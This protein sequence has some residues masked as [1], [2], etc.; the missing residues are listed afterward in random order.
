MVLD[1]VWL[2]CKMGLVEFFLIITMASVIMCTWMAVSSTTNSLHQSGSG[3][4]FFWKSGNWEVL[5]EGKE[6]QD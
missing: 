6:V 3:A 4:T 1:I 5:Y 2:G